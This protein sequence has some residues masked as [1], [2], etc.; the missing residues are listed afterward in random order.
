MICFSIFTS[1]DNPGI[2]PTAALQLCVGLS[3]LSLFQKIGP[4]VTALPASHPLLGVSESSVTFL[5]MDCQK[6][7]SS[8]LLQCLNRR[9]LPS[10]L[11]EISKMWMGQE[12]HPRSAPRITQEARLQVLMMQWGRR[13]MI[14]KQMLQGWHLQDAIIWGSQEGWGKPIVTWNTLEGT[15][16]SHT[17]SFVDKYV[18]MWPSSVW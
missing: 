1:P 3:Y 2:S 9:C 5:L 10:C 15:S 11:R 7:F 17:Q 14:W 4:S 6:G 18:V 12:L 8:L 16:I 13:I